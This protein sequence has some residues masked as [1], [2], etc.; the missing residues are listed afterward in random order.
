MMVFNSPDDKFVHL[1]PVFPYFSCQIPECPLQYQD[2]I[3]TF[4]SLNKDLRHLELSDDEWN[5]IQLVAKWLQQFDIATSEMSTMKKPMLS[6][7]HS[8][9]ANLYDALV[10]LPLNIDPRLKAGLLKLIQSLNNI[11]ISSISLLTIFGLLVCEFPTTYHRISEFN[12][13]VLDPQ[14]SY[15]GLKEDFNESSDLQLLNDLNKAKQEL[16]KLY[17]EHYAHRSSQDNILQ[18]GTTTMLSGAG[19]SILSTSS[20]TVR[21]QCRGPQILNQLEDYFRLSCELDFDGCDPLE[22]WQS[23]RK[24]WPQLYCLACDILAIPG[25][26]TCHS[27]CSS[28]DLV[29]PGSAIAIERIFS[30]GHDIISL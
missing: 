17:E 4:V 1:L 2:E 14:I 24:R 20:F 13:P 10:N 18:P 21:Y 30:S 28:P 22:W 3:N 6:F 19:F 25:V 26:L 11:I 8:L 29:F 9:Q 7:F 15:N 27:E 16:F 23:H 5:S 12:H